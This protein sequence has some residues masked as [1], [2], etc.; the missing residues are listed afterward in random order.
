MLFEAGEA[1][2]RTTL[3]PDRL[4]PLLASTT[5]LQT[6]YFDLAGGAAPAADL[7]EFPARL[8]GTG[9]A[10]VRIDWLGEGA[11]LLEAARAWRT[12]HLVTIDP[13]ALSPI[14]DC[15]KPFETYLEDGGKS[16]RKY[17]KAC[18]RHILDG[19]LTID[20][21]TGG[22]GL[23]A[24]LEEMFALEAAGWKGREGTAI[25]AKPADR[26]FYTAL[27]HEAAAAGALRIAT[28]RE[29]GRLLA[30]EYCVVAS[31]TILA[32]KVGYDESRANLQLGH[33]LALMNIR[34]ACGD[35][36]IAAYDMLG[37]GMRVADYKKKFASRYR[38]IYRVRLFAR[39]PAGRL[40]YAAYRARPWVKRL[41]DRVRSLRRGP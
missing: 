21:V 27:A 23:A 17:W 5:N 28:L 6:C 13:F 32:M 14:A 10:Q 37:N 39:T 19:P 31:D 33:M 18:R 20:F 3:L 8:L 29:G 41:R 11:R 26:R 9:A 15:R 35:P 16:L 22:P 30:Y 40:L 2:L 34:D 7:D 25:L 12:G 24:L 1:R 38:T 36:A 4:G